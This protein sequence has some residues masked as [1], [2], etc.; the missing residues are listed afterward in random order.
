MLQ[1][2]NIPGRYLYIYIYDSYLSAL[3]IDVTSRGGG[4]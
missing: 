2:K 4:K 3:H 1:Y